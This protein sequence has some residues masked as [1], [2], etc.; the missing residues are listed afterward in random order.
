MVVYRDVSNNAGLEGCVISVGAVGT[1]Y[2]TYGTN[3]GGDEYYDEN[4]QFFGCKQVEYNSNY[5]NCL[6]DPSTCTSLYAAPSH[7]EKWKIDW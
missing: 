3:L 2:D 4:I 7:N 1:S 6:A 5:Q